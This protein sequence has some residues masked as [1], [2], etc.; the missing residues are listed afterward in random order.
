MLKRAKREYCTNIFMP[1]ISSPL[2]SD[3]YYRSKQKSS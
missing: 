2:I 3:R 1:E